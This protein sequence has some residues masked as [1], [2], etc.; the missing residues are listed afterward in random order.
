[1]R[2]GV[3]HLGTSLSLRACVGA[4]MLMARVHCSLWLASFMMAFGTPT[5]EMVILRAEIFMSLIMNSTAASTDRIV[6]SG[7]PMPMNTANEVLS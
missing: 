7:S 5:V 4:W 3:S 1:M 6:S 2:G